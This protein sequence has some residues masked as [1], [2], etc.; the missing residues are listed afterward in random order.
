MG[1]VPAIILSVVIIAAL[2]TG[3]LLV[4]GG[5]GAPAPQPTEGQVS[6]L[7]WSSFTDEGLD[8]IQRSREIRID[9]SDKAEDAVIWGC[10]RTARRSSARTPRA[11]ST[12][13][14]S[15]AAAR[16]RAATS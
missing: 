14:P 2:V 7:N 16:V 11:S 12:S 6:D 1:W 4:R 5:L 15:R 13:S 8:Y 10:R 3:F 9:L